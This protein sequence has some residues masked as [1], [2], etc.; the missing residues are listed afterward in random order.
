ML[1]RR[2]ARYH[3]RHLSMR[4]RVV[5]QRRLFGCRRFGV[6]AAWLVSIYRFTT[7]GGT[8]HGDRSLREVLAASLMRDLERTGRGWKRQARAWRGA[9]ACQTKSPVQVAHTGR[10]YKSPVLIGL[11]VASHASQQPIGLTGVRAL[12]LRASNGVFI[13]GYTIADTR[14]AAAR[15]GSR[16]HGLVVTPNRDCYHCLCAPVATGI[17]RTHHHAQSLALQQGP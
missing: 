2:L 9:H 16:Q 1:W 14:R 10:P 4:R 13:A 8:R 3:R 5:C 7:A 17:T 6:G 12:A 15:M 11:G